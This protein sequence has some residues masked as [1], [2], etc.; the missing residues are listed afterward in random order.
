MIAPEDM[1][2]LVRNDTETFGALS[3]RRI[4]P[5]PPARDLEV[6]GPVRIA[7]GVEFEARQGEADV[8]ALW[9]PDLVRPVLLCGERDDEFRGAGV[10]RSGRAG[11]L[12][13]ADL[14]VSRQGYVQE[15]HDTHGLVEEFRRSTLSHADERRLCCEPQQETTGK[16]LLVEVRLGTVAHVGKRVF[17]QV[18]DQFGSRHGVAQF[19]MM[20]GGRA[21]ADGGRQS[22]RRRRISSP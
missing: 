15:L 1:N 22:I 18:G 6:E 9:R 20:N 5:Y 3:A 2:K 11:L 21:V 7:G 17:A 4:D 12:T 14:P 16:Q 10:G 8:L 19:T 13:E